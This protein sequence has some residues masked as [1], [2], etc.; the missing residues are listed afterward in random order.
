[1]SLKTHFVLLCMVYTYAYVVAH[2]DFSSTCECIF[3]SEVGF[4][5]RQREVNSSRN[6][7]QN[8]QNKGGVCDPYRS[9]VACVNIGYVST[10][11][12]VI[13]MS[14]V[15]GVVQVL[16][17]YCCRGMAVPTFSEVVIITWL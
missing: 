6:E 2:W 10:C 5:A 4:R 11:E 8:N 17:Q 9:S 15:W 12:R 1:M 16:R 3:L 13:F 7:P 14:Y